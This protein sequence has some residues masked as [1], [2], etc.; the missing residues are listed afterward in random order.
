[1][2]N[3]LAKH[4]DV[5]RQYISQL[6]AGERDGSTHVLKKIANSLNVDLDDIVPS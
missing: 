2:Q 6:E 3:D 5:S 4:V 1:L